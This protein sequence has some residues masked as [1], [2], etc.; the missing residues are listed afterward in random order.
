MQAA[1]HGSY[2]VKVV[3]GDEYRRAQD[4]ICEHHQDAV[5]PDTSTKVEV[6][7]QLVTTPSEAVQQKP[8]Q[9]TLTAPAAEPSVAPATPKQAAA[10]SPTAATRTQQ[11]TSLIC[12]SC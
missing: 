5:K 7:G 2:I 12:I 8:A 4:H 10:Q 11:K 3:G 1:D 9:H 6:A